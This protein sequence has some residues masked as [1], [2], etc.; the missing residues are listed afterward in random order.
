MG[1]ICNVSDESHDILRIIISENNKQ[2][3]YRLLQFACYFQ[4]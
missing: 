3:D 4:V 1:I 2:K